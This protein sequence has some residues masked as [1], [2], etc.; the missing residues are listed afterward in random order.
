ME[1]TQDKVIE[2]YMYRQLYKYYVYVRPG[3]IEYFTN[4]EKAKEYADNF[5]GVEVKELD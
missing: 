2:T 4:Y 5:I 3:V 1:K